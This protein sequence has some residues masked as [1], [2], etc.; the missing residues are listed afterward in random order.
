MEGSFVNGT[1][2]LHISYFSVSPPN[3]WHI[4]PLYG[5]FK[6][7]PPISLFTG[8][9]D[10]LNPDAVIL[11]DNLLKENLAINYHEYPKMIHDWMFFN[12]PE[13]QSC[14]KSIISLFK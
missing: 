6:E 9:A 2:A 14:I 4:S 10:I 11:K 12:I 8:T 5:N 13:A 7:L 1:G 3:D